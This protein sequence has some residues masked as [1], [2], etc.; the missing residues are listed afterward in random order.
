MAARL[1]ARDAMLRLHP[2]GLEATLDEGLR[3][4]IRR[5]ILT[6][7]LAVVEKKRPLLAY[8]AASLAQRLE[9]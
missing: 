4:L 9:I 6:A 1:S 7:D 8:Y 2:D 5:D 3:H